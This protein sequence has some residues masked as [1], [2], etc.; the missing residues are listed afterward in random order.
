MKRFNRK[1]RGALFICIVCLIAF[2]GFSRAGLIF[3][4]ENLKVVTVTATERRFDSNRYVAA[5]KAYSQLEEVET[6]TTTTTTTSTSQA[7]TIVPTTKQETQ[8]SKDSNVQED[9]SLAFE[10]KSVLEVAEVLNK[11][12]GGILV[13]QGEAFA[14]LSMEK[15]M[16]PYLLVAISIHETGNGTS[17]AARNK[18]NFGGLMCSGRL[19]TYSSVEDGIEKYINIVYKN[20]FSQGLTTAETM[21]KKYAAST[22]WAMQVNAWYDRI[23]NK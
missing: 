11:T 10:G 20:Y 12:L 15:G 22:S 4:N 5:M 7:T 2:I 21:N 9:V 6:T 13:N 19:C 16:D 18:Y 3:S 17:S 23:K 8:E 14:R 1:L